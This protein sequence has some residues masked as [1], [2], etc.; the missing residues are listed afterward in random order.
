MANK[1]FERRKAKVG[2]AKPGAANRTDT[3]F[4]ARRLVVREQAL[5][6]AAKVQRASAGA[7]GGTADAAQLAAELEPVLAQMG[8][9][10][11]GQRASAASRA[12]RALKG[13]PPA[14]VAS[15]A[16]PLL[17]ATCR[18]LLDRDQGVRTA[19]SGLMSALI[20]GVAPGAAGAFV[21]RP[22]GPAFSA[23]LSHVDPGVR[24]GALR[25]LGVLFSPTGVKA[26]GR[27]GVSAL[28]AH[29]APAIVAAFPTTAGLA[30]PSAM[31]AAFETASAALAAYSAARSPTSSS[32]VTS[33]PVLD[34]QPEG[35]VC[36]F[37]LPVALSLVRVRPEGTVSA[38]PLSSAALSAIAKWMATVR[39]GL[40][41]AEPADGR[42]LGM[43]LERACAASDADLQSVISSASIL[44][45]HVRMLMTAVAN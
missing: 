8:H 20:S 6:T 26:L 7:H 16:G 43:L 18:A 25:A 4:V 3:S 31:N 22:L 14:A 21:A 5:S 13:R 41:D 36:Y 24:S 40:R 12:A 38:P 19:A 32:E 15:A 37:S 17:T 23:G 39:L 29:A 33:V 9:H 2:R 11:A 27:E 45:A 28:A 10:G 1:D 30:T 44:P 42:A 35:D 34:A